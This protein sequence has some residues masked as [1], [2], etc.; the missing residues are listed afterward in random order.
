[1]KLKWTHRALHQVD[2][3]FVYIAQ[4]NPTAAQQVVE[5]IAEASRKL[6]D[7]PNIGKPGR[8]AGTHEWVV[9]GTPYI[10]FYVLTGD[11]VEIIRVLHSKQSWPPKR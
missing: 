7:H 3:A 9:T 10:I 1:M 2:E 11:T 6:L 8:V 4:D 5:R